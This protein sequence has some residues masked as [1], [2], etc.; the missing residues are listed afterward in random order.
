[1]YKCI[2]LLLCRLTIAVHPRLPRGLPHPVPVFTDTS[3]H[4][5]SY[6]STYPSAM[7]HSLWTI[8]PLRPL[9]YPCNP[10]M[11]LSILLI[12]HL[13][14]SPSY[15]FQ[16]PTSTSIYN[17]HPTISPSTCTS[18][19]LTQSTIHHSFAPHCAAAGTASILGSNSTF[20]SLS[21]LSSI[22]KW[23]GL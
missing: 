3:I 12:L 19:S 6:S 1:M 4:S 2:H 16:P 9:D 17:S 11:H 23:P 15:P 18:Y 21:H 20:G 10:S 22:R 14:I 7:D 13:F 8:H 5:S